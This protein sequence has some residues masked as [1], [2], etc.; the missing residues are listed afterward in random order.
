M[1]NSS[2]RRPLVPLV[3]CGT[4]VTRTKAQAQ[5]LPGTMLRT[6]E[7][8][9]NMAAPSTP[10]IQL[11]FRNI[12]PSP[13]TSRQPSYQ[14]QTM[15]AIAQ[16]TNIYLFSRHTRTAKIRNGN[17]VTIWNPSEGSRHCFQKMEGISFLYNLYSFQR[18]E[19]YW[20]SLF[21]PIRFT[22][23]IPFPY[24]LKMLSTIT[25]ILNLPMNF[26]WIW[27]RVNITVVQQHQL[28][29][30]VTDTQQAPQFKP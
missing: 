12:H 20:V 6:Q 21:H 1:I 26:L 7:K 30:S 8:I 16:V 28:L 5:R 22:P 25:Q 13:Q 14:M 18:K 11:Q 17:Y 9:T 10:Q 2:F 24:C 15:D 19:I 23:G 3:S 4:S 27:K 29:K